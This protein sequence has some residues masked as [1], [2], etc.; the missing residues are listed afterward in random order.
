MTNPVDD[1]PIGPGEIALPLDLADPQPS[2]KDG[3]RLRKFRRRAFYVLAVCS[4]LALVAFWEHP[5]SVARPVEEL[6]VNIAEDPRLE[7]YQMPESAEYCAEW[8]PVAATV[9]GT[10]QLA[11]ASFELPTAADLLFFLSRGPV[12]GHINI[13]QTTSYSM[14]PIEVNVT[15]EYKNPEDLE[16]TKVCR[17]GP[18]NEHGVLVWA[19]PRHPHGDPRRDVRINV[20]VT[21][22]SGVRNYKDLTTDLPLFQHAVG[23]FFDIW[24][25]TSF[26]VIRLKTSN[27]AINHGSLM[28]RS[29][30]IQTSNAKIQGMFSGL[31]LSVQTS[32][33]PIG[34]TAMM[35]A[36][37][38]GSESRVNI[39]TSNGAI[40]ANL[41]LISDYKDNV[42]RA[43]VQTSGA[44]LTIGTERLMLAANSSLLLDASTSVGPANVY[45]YPE[46]Q[47]TYDL[48]TSSWARAQV[49]AKELRDVSGQGRTRT[50]AKASTGQRTQGIVYW[51]RDGKPTEGVK[52]GSVK[53]TTSKSPV[54]LYC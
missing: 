41:G 5:P 51:S 38:A 23:E 22:P 21:L 13:V 10:A 50:V 52:R 54:K 19:Q 48:T 32:N 43:V 4:T 33:A 15:A 8:A 17:M 46:Y 18:A 1:A 12:S 42:L 26:E 44:S 31:E 20:T 27:A 45:L 29:G 28:G 36:E 37:S 7:A 2:V 11:S 24:S 6:V 49:E 39:K 53:V 16:R 14:D 34:C 9:S 30:F 35:F 25:P 40:T 3:A 47:G